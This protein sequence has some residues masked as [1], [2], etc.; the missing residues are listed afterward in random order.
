MNRKWTIRKMQA[1]DLDRICEIERTC[2]AG[3]WSRESFESE[4][5]RNGGLAVVAETESGAAGYAVGWSAADE[6][7]IANLAV[8][9]E[10]RRKGMGRGLLKA[11]LNGF[12]GL[13]WA[14]L[15]VRES[16]TAA[17]AL[18]QGMGFRKS[19]IRKNY[20]AEEKEDAVLMEM[21]IQ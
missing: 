19:K 5:K 6:L 15:E 18:Y 7:H 13:T 4:L 10:W 20:Y 17:I 11:L 16:N 2:F 9:P 21:A 12:S 8:H 3:P 1:G 14:G